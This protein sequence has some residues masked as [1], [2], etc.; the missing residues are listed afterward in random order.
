MKVHPGPSFFQAPG[1]GTDFCSC[2][3]RQKDRKMFDKRAEKNVD[4]CP[5]KSTPLRG[6]EKC[7]ANGPGRTRVSYWGFTSHWD[8]FWGQVLKRGHRA[9]RTTP[10][11]HISIPERP[12][13]MKEK[14]WRTYLYF[15]YLALTP[16]PNPPFWEL[17]EKY[18]GDR[19]LSFGDLLV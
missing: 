3:V 16:N 10:D 14:S 5:N 11:C 9:L 12:N 13:L 2:I 4:Q 8:T 17:G 18:C 19:Y 7:A 15:S 6:Q 1:W